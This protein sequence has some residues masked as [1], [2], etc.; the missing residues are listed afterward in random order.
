M[1]R[2][3]KSNVL[4]IGVTLLV[5]SLCLLL[6]LLPAW[7]VSSAKNDPQLRQLP[8]PTPTSTP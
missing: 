4:I 8:T 1:V 5:V 3:T 2:S 6:M 7:S